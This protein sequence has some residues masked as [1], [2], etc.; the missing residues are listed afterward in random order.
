[1]KSSHASITNR[2]KIRNPAKISVN[3][4]NKQSNI[5]RGGLQSLRS[6]FQKGP[7]KNKSK[8]YIKGLKY[9]LK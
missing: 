1:M 7:L 4:K 2:N 6:G 9:R 5:L 3:N 8:M